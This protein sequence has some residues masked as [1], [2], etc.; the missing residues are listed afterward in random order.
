MGAPNSV[1]EM[2]ADASLEEE[3]ELFP[4]VL[5]FVIEAGAASTSMIQRKFRIGYNRAARMIDLLEEK[6]YISAAN[7]SK[8]REVFIDQL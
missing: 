7:G 5:A 8:P 6:G 1:E 3:D 4:E 2:V